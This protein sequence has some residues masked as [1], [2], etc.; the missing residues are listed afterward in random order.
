MKE[1]MECPACHTVLAKGEMLQM[2]TLV[3]HVLNPNGEPSWKQSFHCPNASC[4]TFEVEYW[5]EFGETYTH[6]FLKSREIC[7]IDN[8]RSPFNSFEREL[9]TTQ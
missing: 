3:E 5:N 4:P 7:Y 8:N 9:N 1:P 6:D 2:Q